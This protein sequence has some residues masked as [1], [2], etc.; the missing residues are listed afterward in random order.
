MIGKI[1]ILILALFGYA[2]GQEIE[3]FPHVIIGA[4]K[5]DP[6]GS[7]EFNTFKPRN[8]PQPLTPEQLRKAYG[9]SNN[10]TAGY[11]KTIA[12]IDAFGAST[13]EDDLRIFSAEYNLPDCTISNGCLRK[14]NQTGGSTLP[15]DDTISTWGLEAATDVQAVHAIAPGARILYV[16]AKSPNSND[17][18]AAVRY[19][20]QHANYVSMSW[21]SPEGSYATIFDESYFKPYASTVGFFASTGDNGSNG[22]IS[23]P[24]SSKYIVAVGGTSIQL[25]EEGA[26]LQETGWSG[27]GGGCS[28]FI[29]ANEAETVARIQLQ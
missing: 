3:F 15:P 7:G 29:P 20:S 6:P 28:N 27:S 8:G 14:V 16:A 4:S 24:A 17:L 9:L 10:N 22:G 13:L 19:A 2:F 12:I 5:Q 18:F 26:I 1:V 21:G 23:Y 11:G 25:N